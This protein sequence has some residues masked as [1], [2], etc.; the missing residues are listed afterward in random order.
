MRFLSSFSASLIVLGLGATALA[1]PSSRTTLEVGAFAEI[2]G[3]P[4]S[5]AKDADDAAL[6]AAARAVLAH[7]SAL[8]SH[9]TLGAS[10]TARLVDGQRIVKLPQ[11]HAGLPVL[12]RGAAVAFGADGIARLV[13]SKLAEDLPGDPT[14]QVDAQTAAMAASKVAGVDM[15]PKSAQLVFW[16]SANGVVLAWT[17]YARPLYAGPYAPY[18]VVDAKTGE[19]IVRYNAALTVHQ[20]KV[21]PTNPV[22]SPVTTQ[23]TVP[24]PSGATTVSSPLIKARNCIDTKKTKP[25]SF[26]GFTVDI[27]ACELFHTATAAQGSLDFNQTPAEDTAPE[28][29]FAE[30]HIGY[31]AMRVYQMFQGYQANFTV[32][33]T[34]L[35]VVAN[36]R[37]PQG[38]N[39]FD[40]QKMS[41]PN[42]PLEPFQNAFFSPADPNN[43]IASLFGV[44]G[45]GLYFGQGP[46]K[47]YSYDADVIYHEFG[48]AV[49]N[50]TAKLAG[51]PH[52]D[53]YGVVYSP[54]GMNEGFADYFSSALSGDPDVG[55][56]VI[57][58]YDPAGTAIRS[59]ANPDA[60]PTAIG[61]EVHQDATLFSGALW[62]VRVALNADQ[63]P[64]LDLAVFTALNTVPSGDMS[65]DEM[66][67]LII[68]AVQASPLGATGAQSLEQAFTKRGVLPQCTRILPYAGS[69]M[70]GPIPVGPGVGA[71]FAPGVQSTGLKAPLG[72][73]PGVLQMHLPLAGDAT[74]LKI[75]FSGANVGQGGFGGGTPFSPRVLVRF[76]AEP[77]TFTYGPYGTN[78]DAVLS[79]PTES[80]QQ[81][82]NYD[83]SVPVPAGA[84]GAYIMIVNAGDT[85]GVF[86]AFS[87]EHDGSDGSGATSSSGGNGSGSGGGM[88]P[89]GGWGG[90][91]GEGG[92][93]GNDAGPTVSEGSCGCSVPG[94][95]HA[96]VGAAFAAIAGL[97]AIVARR[98]RR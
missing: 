32:Q 1:A 53:E 55:E 35:D 66:A 63:K 11:T 75:N 90:E 79:T 46:N 37:M 65:Y 64:Q 6:D 10:H 94:E 78:Q 24:L 15:D 97:G 76:G 88:N 86:T 19:V 30:L 80:G 48:H 44:T 17:L 89:S 61:G 26:G 2:A 82:K 68:A 70:S 93:G 18:V 34:P 60:C 3:K 8:A 9:V 27:H 52:L 40:L 49:I 58:D 91:G 21:Y 16:P 33:A 54:G 73:S 98:R 59:L 84:K 83:T 67:K 41:D 56:H 69:L 28:D 5:V 42:L 29:P 22:K 92:G 38:L 36:V 14:P 50:V 31:H 23:V 39:N 7:K 71:W 12:H 20:A 45:A 74:T 95:T 87:L 72:Y 47:D 81:L 43:A 57:K 77:I 51:T 4:L 96:P 62:D 25:I 85:D 13:S